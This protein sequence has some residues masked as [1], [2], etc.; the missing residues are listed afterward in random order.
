[1]S[2]INNI[3]LTSML[4]LTLG[5]AVDDFSSERLL[6]IEVAAT[7]IGY[8]DEIGYR[9]KN[10]DAEFGLRLGAQNEEWRTTVRFNFMKAKGRG[11]QKA[12]LDFDRFVWASLYKTDSIVFKPYLGA[13]IG[14]MRYTDDKFA[15][16]SGSGLAYGGQLGLTLNVLDEVD[17]DLG[18]R[19]TIANIDAIEST[20][21]FV[22]SANYLY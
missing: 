22:F 1:M 6:G 17:F 21:S 10:E 5:H 15:D 11:Y 2:T 7:T 19:H 13:H 9:Q 12:M 8:A 18:Y 20:G 4:T 16:K 3:I 14:W